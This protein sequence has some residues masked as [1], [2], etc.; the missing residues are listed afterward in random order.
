MSRF[1]AKSRNAFPKGRPQ[2]K[3]TTEETIKILEYIISNG[4]LEKPTAKS[5]YEKLIR[6]TGVDANWSLCKWKVRNLK[7]G[8]IKALE[9]QNTVGADMIRSENG[10]VNYVLDK[11]LRMS[12]HFKRLREI[13]GDIVVKNSQVENYEIKELTMNDFEM[14]PTH[15]PTPQPQTS[16]STTMTT[17]SILEN[18]NSQPFINGQKDASHDEGQ[19]IYNRDEQLTIEARRLLLEERRVKLDEQKMQIDY[20][21]EMQKL[22][23][24]YEL[25]KLQMEKDERIQKYEL[26]LKYKIKVEQ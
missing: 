3:W 14:Q 13:F 18:S 6:Q 12:P 1:S 20:E 21:I 15:V 26:E 16:L 24:E 11:V 10:D 8:Y 9:W 7:T 19:Q 2:K 25:K 4:N 23:Q 17:T 22:K 5:Y